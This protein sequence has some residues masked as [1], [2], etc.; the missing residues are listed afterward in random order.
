MGTAEV[1]TAIAWLAGPEAEHTTGATLF[2]DG[3]MA[4]HD[5]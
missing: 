5:R 2:L 3:G 4:L 1:A